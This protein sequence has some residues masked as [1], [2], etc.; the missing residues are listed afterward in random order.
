MLLAKGGHHGRHGRHGRHIRFVLFTTH[1]LL[2][3]LQAQ[4]RCA[5]A[6]LSLASVC[7]HAAPHPVSLSLLRSRSEAFLPHAESA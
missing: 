1:A 7:P 3:A 4:R 2:R 5:L 6:V